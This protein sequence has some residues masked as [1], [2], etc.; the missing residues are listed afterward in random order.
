MVRVIEAI[1][2]NPKFSAKEMVKTSSERK[3][4]SGIRQGCPL[5]PYLFIIVTTVIMRDIN[6]SSR[7]KKRRSTDRNGGIR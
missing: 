3:H 6:A 1:Y 7:K 2:R 5:S 4:N